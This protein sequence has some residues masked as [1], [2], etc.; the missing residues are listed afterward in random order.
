[1]G[2]GKETILWWWVGRGLGLVSL[3]VGGVLGW[4]VDVGWGCW[5]GLWAAQETWHKL[6][7]AVLTT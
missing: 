5:V 4:V 2:V 3:V 7:T 6:P 1:M